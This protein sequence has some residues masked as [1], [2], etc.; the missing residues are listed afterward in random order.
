VAE[1]EAQPEIMVLQAYKIQAV[2]AGAAVQ[3]IEMRQLIPRQLATV[4]LVAQVL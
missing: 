3:V 1:L 4:P 2:A